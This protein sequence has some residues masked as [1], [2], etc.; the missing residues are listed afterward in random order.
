MQSLTVKIIAI[1]NSIRSGQINHIPHKIELENT[2]SANGS[3][4]APVSD[5]TLYLRAIYPSKKSLIAPKN[6]MPKA[7][8][9]WL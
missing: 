7:K 1:M 8:S 4:N 3:N 6:T 2:L 5:S 9:V